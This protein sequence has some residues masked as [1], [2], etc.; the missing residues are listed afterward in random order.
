M[1]TAQNQDMVE[2]Q[3]ILVNDNSRDNTS[4]IIHKLSEEDS[5]IIIIINNEKNKGSLYSR[6]IGI[7]SSKGKYIMNSDND[8]LFM[9]QTVFDIIYNEAETGNFDNVEFYAYDIHTYRPRISQVVIDFFHNKTEGLIVRKPNLLY[10][11]ISVN[12]ETFFPND[13][14]VWGRLVKANLYKKAIYELGFTA[15]G[16]ERAKNFICWTEDIDISIPLFSLA[17][18][19]NLYF[20]LCIKTNIFIYNSKR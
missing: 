2:I 16:E 9:D 8:D 3:I 12:N 11:P 4:Q 7:L 18:F 20:S 1:R 13:Y 14:H 15:L 6:N 19:F 5:R 10:F 17:E